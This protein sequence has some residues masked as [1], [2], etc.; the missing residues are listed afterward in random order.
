[1]DPDSDSEPEFDFEWM[2]G[3]YDGNT[4]MDVL[5]WLLQL[6]WYCCRVHYGLCVDIAII[7]LLCIIN[8]LQWMHLPKLF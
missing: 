3:A 4:F 1:M 7:A 5:D 6:L 8:W 2:D